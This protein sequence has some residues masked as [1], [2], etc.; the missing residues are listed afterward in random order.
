LLF[1]IIDIKWGGNH[2]VFFIVFGALVIIILSIHSVSAAC[3]APTDLSID[4]G[5][6]L[7]LGYDEGEFTVEWEAGVGGDGVAN[8]TVFIFKDGSLYTTETNNSGTSTPGYSFSSFIEANYTFL[9]GAMNATEAITYAATNVSVYVDRTGPVITYLSY[10]NET[11]KRNSG[12]LTINVSITDSKSGILGSICLIDVNGV[13][14]SI[15]VSEGFCIGTVG[16]IGL[17]DGNHIINIYVNDTLDNLAVNS[18]YVVSIDTT[19]PTPTASCTP[20]SVVSG[21]TV[22]CTCNASAETGSGINSSL[23]TAN[24]TITTSSTGTFSYTCSVTDNLGNRDSETASY[25]VTSGSSPP[26]SSG[27]GGG[28]STTTTTTDTETNTTETTVVIAEIDAGDDL[29]IVE[30]DEEAGIKEIQVRVN[31]DAQGVKIIVSKYEEKPEGISIEK[32]GEV[33]QYI[34]IETENLT[35][36]LESAIITIRVEKSWVFENNITK[37]NLA[38]F[39]LNN[40]TNKWKE[41]ATVYKEEDD[42]YYYFDSELKSFSYFAISISEKINRNKILLWAGIIVLIAVLIVLGIYLIKN[43]EKKT[44]PV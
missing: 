33:Y 29:I 37:D 16:L 41:L 2:Q 19:A 8:F 28:G 14:Q 38:L 24:S 6:L 39:K 34:E 43:R 44:S 42:T 35:D 25:T 13:N 40:E 30:F 11:F 12:N 5:V 1:I 18:N 36:N 17:I 9:I 31:N 26:S 21:A 10:V 27:G 3:A 22:T 23:T 15:P 32:L 4:Y 20:S 7:K